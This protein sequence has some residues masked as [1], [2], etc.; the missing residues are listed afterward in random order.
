MSWIP[1][2]QDDPVVP[3]DT[4]SS[5]QDSNSAELS[6]LSP[7]PKLHGLP[8][9]PFSVT[10]TPPQVYCSEKE[11]AVFQTINTG[12]NLLQH[13]LS[14]FSSL[15]MTLWQN[16]SQTSSFLKCTDVYSKTNAHILDMLKG[17][18]K[19]S[20]GRNVFCITVYCVDKLT[21]QPA[22]ASVHQVLIPSTLITETMN[23]LHGN[24]CCGH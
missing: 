8:V 18:F 24:P 1:L 7:D 6:V 23:I 11:P 21:L 14:S 2:S 4:L 5:S 10:P 17:N 22:T 13:T 20:F 9:Q 3:K 19:E 15:V 16:N 12:M